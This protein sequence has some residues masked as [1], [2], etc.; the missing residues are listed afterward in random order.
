[1]TPREVF[2][3]LAVNAD[4]AR[5]VCS[6]LPDDAHQ[7]WRALAAAFACRI[8]TG[9][10]AVAGIGGG[11][12]AGKSTLAGLIERALAEFAKRTLV[13]SLD[14]F[15]LRRAQRVELARRVHPLLATRGV[16]GTHDISLLM[17][18]LSSVFQ[19]GQHSVPVF[20]KGSDDRLEAPR[21]IAGP[22]D[23]VIIEG[24]CVGA[25]AQPESRL[26]TP[27]NLL[28]RSRDSDGAWR[29]YVNGQLEAVYEPLW[30][31]LDVLLYLAVPSLDQVIAWRGEQENE[32]A[33]DQRMTP[34]QIQEFV[35]HYERLTLWMLETL[36]DT[37]D[38]VGFLDLDH[39]LKS[40]RLHG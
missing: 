4:D 19:A 5:R 29:R 22:V 2:A 30:K 21:R 11:Q 13:V 33:P 16:P 7:D 17:Q 27:C 34:A 6:A 12:G 31:M 24:W 25:R 32:R 28:E 26:E 35:A 10:C 20:D 14:D 18:V 9:N 38:I 36:P 1:M 3:A 8:V 39:T 15:Y 23:V 37:C 40:L